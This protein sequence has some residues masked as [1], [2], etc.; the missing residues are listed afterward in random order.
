MALKNWMALRR[1]CVVNAVVPKTLMEKGSD[2]GRFVSDADKDCT[3]LQDVDQINRL[4]E[5]Y[6]LYVECLF[7]SKTL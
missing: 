5:Q 2:P 4:S 6:I 3:H 7:L 1:R